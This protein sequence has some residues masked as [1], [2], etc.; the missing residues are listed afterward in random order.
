[1]RCEEL[2][3]STASFGPLISSLSTT[4]D[5]AAT[6]STAV[7]P[8]PDVVLSGVART[9]SGRW[10]VVGGNSAN[11]PGPKEPVNQRPTRG[12]EHLPVLS[13]MRPAGFLIRGQ[14]L[15]ALLLAGG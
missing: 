5:G 14:D 6:W 4:I 10:V 3:T 1:L 11:G 9:P 2:A 13:R 12:S 15:P 8:S 7:L